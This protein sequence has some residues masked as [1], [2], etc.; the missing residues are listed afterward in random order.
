MHSELTSVSFGNKVG[1]HFCIIHAILFD[2]HIE[3]HKLNFL[4]SITRQILVIFVNDLNFESPLAIGPKCWY[5]RF[6][7]YLFQILKTADDLSYPV[8]NFGAGW[9]DRLTDR[10]T[11]EHWLNRYVFL[12]DCKYIC[13][14]PD[15]L[16]FILHPIW[17]KIFLDIQTDGQNGWHDSNIFA[18]LKRLQGI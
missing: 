16:F 8:R 3:Y 4:I 18:Q 2:T 1:I 11:N 17:P 14:Y 13:P 6:A 5:F 7:V 12:S 9:T 10:R 15:V